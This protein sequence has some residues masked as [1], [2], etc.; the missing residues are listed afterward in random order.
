MKFVK[1][2]SHNVAPDT[3]KGKIMKKLF[4]LAVVAIAAASCASQAK[5]TNTATHQ[6][7]NVIAPTTMVFADLDVSPE[8]I[9]HLYI[10]SKTV[11]NG[12]LDNVIDSAVAEALQANGNADVLV[13]IQKQIKYNNE[14]QIESVVITGYPAKYTNFRNPSDDYWTSEAF[15]KQKSAAA[16][17][18]KKGLKLFGK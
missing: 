16:E 2:Q 10:P 4:I 13:G 5:L 8:K 12:G 15:L 18:G 7:I 3:Y 14:G 6:P 17:T 11:I 1:N 9:T